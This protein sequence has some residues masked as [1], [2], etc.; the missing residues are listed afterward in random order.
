MGSL[1]G[2]VRRM[3]LGNSMRRHLSLRLVVGRGLHFFVVLFLRS[4]LLEV[5]TWGPGNQGLFQP[6]TQSTVVMIVS[7]GMLLV[8]RHL[9]YIL[10][11][12]HD[13]QNFVA[14]GVY[15]GKTVYALAI[16]K[17]Q[18]LKVHGLVVVVVEGDSICQLAVDI[19]DLLSLGHSQSYQLK[20][21]VELELVWIS[22]LQWD[23]FRSLAQLILEA[24]EVV[25]E[26]FVTV[27]LGQLGAPH[28]V[29]VAFD[30]VKFESRHKASVVEDCEA[31]QVVYRP[32]FSLW[33][34]LPNLHHLQ[35]WTVKHLVIDSFRR[36]N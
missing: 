9:L 18:A 26:V 35:T 4:R 28:M 23:L 2:W 17:H 21:T 15:I 19:E 11:A 10:S 12:F 8:H 30:L 36:L 22:Q 20:A 29:S 33:P 5:V 16:L 6:M 31:A 7:L 1:L 34:S 13:Y 32:P 27:E 3:M 24:F 14:F 25:V